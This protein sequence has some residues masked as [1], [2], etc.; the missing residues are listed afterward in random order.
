MC[1][2]EEAVQ[3]QI[4]FSICVLINSVQKMNNY[5]KHFLYETYWVLSGLCDFKQVFTGP[6]P[7]T[8]PKP[9]ALLGF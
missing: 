3:M 2:R 7:I 8:T 9:M 6:S 5:L 1:H 4:I